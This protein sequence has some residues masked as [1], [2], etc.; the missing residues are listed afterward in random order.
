MAK[1][2]SEAKSD[3]DIDI[4]G[5]KDLGE[6]SDARAKIVAKGRK[7]RASQTISDE[8]DV[9]DESMDALIGAEDEQTAVA[10]RM[11]KAMEDEASGDDDDPEPETKPSN[12][13]QVADQLV[14]V[15]IYG[16]TYSV[17]QRDIDK[18]GGLEAYQRIRAA[19][20]RFQEAAATR[21]RAQRQEQEL[22]KREE[23]LKKLE[24]ELKERSSR[25]ASKDAE[26]PA[27]GAHEE[28]ETK[29]RAVKVKEIVDG[30]FSGKEADAEAAIQKILDSVESRPSLSAEQVADMVL[31]K[32]N[33]EQQQSEQQTQDDEEQ[34][35]FQ[36]SKRR[37]NQVMREEY[38]DVMAVPLLRNVALMRFQELRNDPA[39]AGR[40]W[41]D[42][43]REAG[44][45]AK[46]IQ[47]TDPER[48]IETRTAE[49][50][51]MPARSTARDRAR[52]DDGKAKPPSNKSHIERLRQ[53][54]G[55]KQPGG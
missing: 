31:E 4:G 2:G 42:L 1:K 19:N 12:D 10:E 48:E 50:R 23:E 49:K 9:D 17:P 11:A 24:K 21:K 3:K 20:I 54:A 45:Q 51:G 8:V 33:S 5:P 26:P 35:F 41:A 25:T 55:L 36:E 46:K 15:V 53:R 7:R 18:A 28:A 27:T 47:V 6:M 34:A 30:I 22:K 29:D 43:A 38:S 14:D 39:N 32:L 40:D 52:S 44:D 16:R 37:V 13:K